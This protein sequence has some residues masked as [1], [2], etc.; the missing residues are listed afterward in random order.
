MS[1][2]NSEYVPF[3]EEWKKE[4]SKLTKKSIID[5]YR[6]RCKEVINLEGKLKAQLSAPNTGKPEV[7][8][9][10]VGDG[11]IDVKDRLPNNGDNVLAYSN[12]TY[13]QNCSV[14]VVFCDELDKQWK[15]APTYFTDG[16]THWQP[17]PPPPVEQKLTK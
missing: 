9:I 16:I 8:T 2:Q 10:S 15:G 4:V 12:K 13:N 3:G 11:W 7:P 5:L 1:E 17:L 14:E 6:S